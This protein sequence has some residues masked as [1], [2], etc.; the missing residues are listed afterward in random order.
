MAVV[1]TTVTTT[2]ARATRTA[3]DLKNSSICVQH[4]TC[5]ADVYNQRAAA[6]HV[7]LLPQIADV[8]VDD[9]GLQREMVLPHIL[10]QHRPR[11]H[12]AGMT[13]EVFE[14][15]ELARQQIDFGVAAMH[16]LFD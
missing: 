7:D 16:R 2:N 13:Q 11:D 10:E 9:I 3:E 14:K 8:D 6:A 5:S 4:E 12:L 15:L 1:A